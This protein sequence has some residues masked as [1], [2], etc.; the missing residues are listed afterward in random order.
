MTG[1]IKTNTLLPLAAS[2]RP[3]LRERCK[4]A[5]GGSVSFNALRLSRCQEPMRSIPGGF[6]RCASSLIVRTPQYYWDTRRSYHKGT[7][8]RKL[9]RTRDVAGD[10]VNA[11]LELLDHDYIMRADR[12]VVVQ[13]A[14]VQRL[15]RN[16]DDAADAGSDRGIEFE[17]PRRR[18]P[19]SCRTLRPRLSRLGQLHR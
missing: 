15:I 10:I 3:C 13:V 7:Q 12:N 1:A 17:L 19:L 16:A 4:T 5:S 14:V 11:G 2:H 8:N 6:M 9:R 18:C